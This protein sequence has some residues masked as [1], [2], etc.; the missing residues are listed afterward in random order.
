MKVD[1]PGALRSAQSPPLPPL[2]VT[3]PEASALALHDRAR[4]G[5]CAPPAL[6]SRPRAPHMH[7][8]G[9]PPHLPAC[10]QEFFSL[11][12]S[13]PLPLSQARAQR[14]V[15]RGA[16]LADRRARHPVGPFP[17]LWAVQA[18]YLRGGRACTLFVCVACTWC[19][20]VRVPCRPS[21]YA[22]AVPAS[23]REP[24]WV[25]VVVAHL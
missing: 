14:T 4:R 24:L 10:L 17:R 21:V 3:A 15:A 1:R 7:P 6:Q 22:R 5:P 19:R 16:R 9:I 25:H 11:T 8:L 2:P 23:P 12:L 20:A 18:R 13:L